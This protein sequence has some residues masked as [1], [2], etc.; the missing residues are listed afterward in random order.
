MLISKKKTAY[1][2]LEI[3]IIESVLR[4]RQLNQSQWK[5]QIHENFPQQF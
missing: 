3:K 1:Q 2:S 4:Y 5:S